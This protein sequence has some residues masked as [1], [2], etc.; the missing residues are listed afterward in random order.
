M[1]HCRLSWL[2]RKL[3]NLEQLDAKKYYKVFNKNKKNYKNSKKK[4]NY[5]SS[6]KKLQKSLKYQKPKKKQNTQNP[7]KI[8]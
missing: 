5:K 3:I 8:F 2:N 6:K 1:K 7:K 4:K